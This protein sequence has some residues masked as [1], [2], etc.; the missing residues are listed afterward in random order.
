[1]GN[2]TCMG[3]P[4]TTLDKVELDAQ[5][6]AEWK[7]DMLKLDGC[8]STREERE[9]GKFHSCPGPSGREGEVARGARSAC[10]P[11]GWSPSSPLPGSLKM[12]KHSNHL[13]ETLGSA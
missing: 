12:G 11:E 3:Y 10:S 6:F 1:M 5:T 7:V 4:G 9:E 13:L 8:F 2:L